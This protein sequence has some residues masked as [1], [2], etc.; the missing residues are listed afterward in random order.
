MKAL[1][2]YISIEDYFKGQSNIKKNNKKNKI[3]FYVLAIACLSIILFSLYNILQWQINNFNIKHINKEIEENTKIYHNS[4]QGE[5]VNPPKNKNSNYY[6]YTSMPFYQVNFA[7]LSYLNSD[8]VAFI[9][10]PNTNVKYPVVQAKDNDYYL[11][12]SLYQKENKAGWIFMDYRNNINDLNDNTIIYGHSRIDGTMFGSL[13][14]V[15]D[16]SWQSN[17]NNYVI[18]ISTPQENMIFQ[19]FSIY[20]IKKENYYI[21]T[22]FSNNNE[23]QKWL[24]TMKK[25]NIAPINTEVDVNDKILTLSTCYINQDKRIVIQAKLIKKQKNLS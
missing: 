10:L 24:D 16:Y 15:L 14:N 5:L 19:I 17:P 23:K 8:T 25:R 6:D 11:N 1:K 2:K 12:H 7:F 9:Y 18:F 13:K 3:L 21:M 22:K 4:D 20:T